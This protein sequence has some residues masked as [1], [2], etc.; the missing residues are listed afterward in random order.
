MARGGT[1]QDRRTASMYGEWNIALMAVSY[2]VHTRPSLPVSP[3]IITIT[4]STD[5]KRGT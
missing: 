3:L 2:G 4:I 1:W 5:K